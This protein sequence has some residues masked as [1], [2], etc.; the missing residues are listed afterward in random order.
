M[1]NPLNSNGLLLWPSISSD[2]YAN[3]LFKRKNQKTK[4]QVWV[5]Y[6]NILF[7]EKEDFENN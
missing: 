6:S 5:Y 2:Y 3:L 1:Y 4:L 7:E